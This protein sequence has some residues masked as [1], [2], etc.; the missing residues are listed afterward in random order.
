MAQ[1]EAAAVTHPRADTH[2][3][4]HRDEDFKHSSNRAF[5]YTFAAVFLVFAGI[6][7]WRQGS[8]WPYLGAI[9]SAFLLL[10]L[11]AP[12]VLAAPNRM[13]AR[14]GLLLH[15]IVNPLVMGLVF[16]L[17][18]TPIGMIMRLAGKDFLR[19]RFD[20]AAA[21]YWIDRDPPGPSPDGMR[22]QY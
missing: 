20:G 9:A 8:L 15:R 19:L 3:D 5:G 16:F 21:S 14:F 10:S 11:I 12:D 7:L 13:W 4:L 1:T 17:V 22:N 18:V 2:E 6:S